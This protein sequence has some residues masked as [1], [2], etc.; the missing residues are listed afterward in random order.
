MAS[1]FPQF[2]NSPAACD[3]SSTASSEIRLIAAASRR[4]A[5]TPTPLPYAGEGSRF[6]VPRWHCPTGF[7]IKAS[8]FPPFRNPPGA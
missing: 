3:S 4:A 1:L 7:R 2:R 6:S 8:L 5:L